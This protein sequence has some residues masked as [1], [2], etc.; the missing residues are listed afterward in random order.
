[1]V[2]RI[3]HWESVYALRG[4][5]EL[6]W[7]QSDPS[8]SLSLI[9][10][11]CPAGRIIDVGGGTSPLAE[12]LFARGYAV[13]LDISESAIRRGRQRLGARATQVKWIVADVTNP[14]LDSFNLWHDRAVFHF[15]TDRWIALLT[16]RR[17]RGRFPSDT[18]P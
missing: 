8:Q 7:T 12:R 16:S 18:T 3:E 13:V 4:D 10:E 5:A 14:V 6:S 1:M 11:V 9:D 2:G 15:L 17:W